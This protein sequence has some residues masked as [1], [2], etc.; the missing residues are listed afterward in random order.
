M[1]GRTPPTMIASGIASASW[2]GGFAFLA[3]IATAG[4]VATDPG[5]RMGTGPGGPI[6]GI[7]PSQRQAFEAGR[8]EFAEAEVVADG[9]GPRMSLDNCA[10]CHA[11][12]AAGGSSPARNPQVAFAIQN[13]GGNIVPTFVS[14]DGPVRVARLV[15]KT[16]GS[17]SGDILPIFT[18]TGRADAP[19]CKLPQPDFA[20]EARRENIALRIPT[21]LFGGGLIEQIPDSEILANK[22]LRETANRAFGIGGRANVGLSGGTIGQQSN[23]NGNTSEIGRFG[24]KAQHKSVLLFVAEAY[25]QEM[26]ISNELSQE[27]RDDVPGCALDRS[28]S[29]QNELPIDTIRRYHN[30]TGHR[31]VTSDDRSTLD[32]MISIEKFAAFV[33]LL[34][35]PDSVE[36]NAESRQSVDR[37]RAAFERVGCSACHTPT[38]HTGMEATD[39]ALRGQAV[40]LYSDLL[41]HDMGPGLSDGIAQGNAGPR[42]FRTA[43]LWGLGQRLFLLHDGRTKDLVVAIRFHR[44]G[45]AAAGDASE[46]NTVIDT[47]DRL[48]EPDKQDVL[49]FL[50]SL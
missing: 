43:P 3:T 2:I 38:L 34:A 15:R 28:Y 9:L 10:G 29:A 5:A 18:I 12:P 11:H 21:P 8:V 7:T 24:W 23:T 50:R 16:D 36:V 4:S 17:P 39:A 35:P 19:N 41:V 32:N 46:A 27:E 42:D 31:Y 22:A 30:P 44:S 25:N 45:S 40:N 14:V 20:T 1:S 33:R 6:A 26:G 49:N 47:Y 13:R 37:G 48:G